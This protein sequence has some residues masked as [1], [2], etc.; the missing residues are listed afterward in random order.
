[1]HKWRSE[2]ESLLQENALKLD[3][4]LQRRR[5]SDNVMV[6]DQAGSINST[7]PSNAMDDAFESDLQPRPHHHEEFLSVDDYLMHRRQAASDILGRYS[8]SLGTGCGNTMCD[9]KSD[10]PRKKKRVA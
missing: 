7:P 10:Y 6:F 8:G 4:L 2:V 5:Q 3:I 9:Q 1:M